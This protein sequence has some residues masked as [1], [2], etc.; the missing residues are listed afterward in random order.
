MRA[1]TKDASSAT[2]VLFFISPVAPIANPSRSPPSSD[3]NSIVQQLT[4]A[5]NRSCTFIHEPVVVHV[6][7]HRLQPSL[8]QQHRRS[9]SSLQRDPKHSKMQTQ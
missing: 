3:E 9:P 7:Q 4:P 8:S 2:A 5:A 1:H 6:K